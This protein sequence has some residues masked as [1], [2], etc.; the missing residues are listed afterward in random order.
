MRHDV[1]KREVRE[2]IC[3]IGQNKKYARVMSDPEAKRRLKE[4]K[5][6]LSGNLKEEERLAWHRHAYREK[7]KNAGW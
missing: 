7:I 4:L 1:Q 2:I 5:D 6:Q 3:K